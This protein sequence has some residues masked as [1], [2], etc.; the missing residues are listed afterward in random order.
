MRYQKCA[1]CIIQRRKRLVWC[2][3]LRSWFQYLGGLYKLFSM[4]T[5]NCWLLSTA[6][7]CH[8]SG[9]V[10]RASSKIQRDQSM[11][12]LYLHS[13]VVACWIGN[14]GEK[15][16]LPC[17]SS[18]ITYKSQPKEGMNRTHKKKAVALQNATKP[19]QKWSTVSECRRSLCI[20]TKWSTVSG[21]RNQITSRM[22]FRTSRTKN[23]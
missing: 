20:N 22:E 15:Y 1:V 5:T 19:V 18:T 6:E 13:G 11:L 14:T 3:V 17:L 9:S 10:Q 2:L 7:Q 21:C 12:L 23:Y 4:E 16:N 8:H